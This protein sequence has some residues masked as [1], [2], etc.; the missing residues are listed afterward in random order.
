[1]DIT[2]AE[3]SNLPFQEPGVELFG[4]MGQRCDLG[5]TSEEV[6]VHIVTEKGSPGAGQGV[7]ST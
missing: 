7:R 6:G 2:W 4:Q 1:M 5:F 3:T